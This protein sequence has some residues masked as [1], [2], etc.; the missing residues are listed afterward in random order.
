VEEEE[1]NLKALYH[2]SKVQ[3]QDHLNQHKAIS[4]ELPAPAERRKIRC[5]PFVFPQRSS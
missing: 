1:A 3:D 2:A 5:F 4:K